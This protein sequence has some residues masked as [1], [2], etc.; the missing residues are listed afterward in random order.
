M[1]RVRLSNKDVREL[2]EVYSFMSPILEEADVVEVAQVGE[3]RWL[4]LVDGEPLFLRVVHRE[5]GELAIPT[6]FLIHKSQ[7]N[8]LLPQYP[9]A[10]VDVGAVKPIVNGADVMR[11]GVRQISGDFKK[12]DVVL[13]VDEKDRVIAVTYALFDKKEIEQMQKG[14]VFINLHHLGDKVWHASLELAKEKQ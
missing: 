10:Q 6:L 4:Y 12:G 7:K 11:P 14:K 5:L 8:K 3:D 9:K 2:R 1:R 13:I